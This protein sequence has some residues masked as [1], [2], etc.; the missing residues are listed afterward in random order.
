M[1]EQAIETGRRRG[2]PEVDAGSVS[3]VKTLIREALR[4]D[5]RQDGT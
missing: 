5:P 4:V 3:G 2:L 1:L